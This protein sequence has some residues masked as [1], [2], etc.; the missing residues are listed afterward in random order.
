MEKKVIKSN[1]PNYRIKELN[2]KDAERF[3][4]ALNTSKVRKEAIEKAK[5]CK[6]KDM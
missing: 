6:V 4:T 5:N 2:G 3:I 1:I